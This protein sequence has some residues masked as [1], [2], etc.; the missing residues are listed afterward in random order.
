MNDAFTLIQ[1][2][3]RALVLGIGGGGDVVGALAVARLCE[4]L[5]TPFE[6]GGV[7]WERFV[8]DPR[9]GPRP[10]DELIG[11]R[12]VADGALLVDSETRSVDDT[13]VSEAGMAAHLGRDIVLIE[14]SEGPA[15]AAEGI[16]AAAA[17]LGCDLAVYVDVGGDAIARGTEPGLASPLCDAIMLAAGD[18]AADR[19][20]PLGGVFGAG[21]DGELTIDEVLA[22][23]ADLASA[24]TALGAWGMSQPIAAELEDA[25]RVV[26]TEASLQAVRC[27]LGET[28]A[29]AIRQGR[30]TVMLSPVGA[31]T[32]FFELRGAVERALPLA[33][34]VR[35]APGLDAAHEALAALGI[36]SELAYERRRAAESQ[37]E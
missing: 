36:N 14:V 37:A 11:G 29:A 17:E 7:S 20:A 27:A 34:T 5:G 23:V 10:L 30:R 33:R 8:V 21:C 3:E 13:T 28:G 18:L 9:P 19:V 26:P 22:R 25:T 6:L 24:G 35:G 31:L 4:A 1:R 16:A 32:F 2:A 12:R 15:P